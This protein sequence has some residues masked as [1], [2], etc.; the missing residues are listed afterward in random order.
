MQVKKYLKQS[1]LYLFWN[2]PTFLDTHDMGNATEEQLQQAQNA[3]KDEFG[4]TH[5]NILYNVEEDK[6]FCILDAPNKEAVEKTHQKFGMKCNWIT[7]VK[8]TA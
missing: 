4:V 2:M 1:F 5:K 8:T 6:V 7:E 3:P